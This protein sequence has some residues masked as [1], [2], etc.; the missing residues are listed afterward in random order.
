MIIP[1]TLSSA[2]QW[3]AS[4]LALAL[5]LLTTGGTWAQLGI[6]ITTDRPS[7]FTFEPVHVTVTLRN[8][9][10]NPLVF[11]DQKPLAGFVNLKV[12]SADDRT[13][14]LLCPIPNLGMNLI[15]GTGETK[16]LT[17]RL[18]SLFNL[19]RGGSYLV[20]ALA[21]HDRLPDDYR[22]DPAQFVLQSGLPIWQKRLGA[23]AT[24][25]KDQIAARQV[26]LLL[27]TERKTDQFALMVEDDN[28]VYGFKRLGARIS[29]TTP[30][31]D[32]D[33]LSNVHVL[34]MSKPRLF[35]HRVYDRDLR[36]LQTTYY[37]ADRAVPTI[38]RDPDI[39][40]IMITGGRPAIPGVDFKFDATETAAVTPVPAA[41]P[42]QTLHGVP[43]DAATVPAPTP[44]KSPPEAGLQPAHGILGPSA[45]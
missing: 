14:A 44:Q 1:A 17:V 20:H 27:M 10:G 2:R 11:S 36:L 3:R 34:W 33:A 4:V 28:T 29:G 38:Q 7:Y 37:I 42:T 26:C 9:S 12:T 6:Q 19:Q 41:R 15:L 18:D 13:V 43:T 35:E 5:G 39:G 32:V 31:L 30:V 21:G 23:P 24:G 16:D 8:N 45:P 40:R 22:S 25:A